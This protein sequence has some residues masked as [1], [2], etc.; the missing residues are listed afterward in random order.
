MCLPGIARQFG[1]DP[2]PAFATAEVDEAMFANPENRVSIAKLG[3]FA[4]EIAR[5]IDR[6]DLGLLIARTYGS[7]SLGPVLPQA[8]QGH[9][10]RAALLNIIRL[11]KH[12]NELALLSLSETDGDAILNYE[13]REPEFEGADIVLV[14]SPR[15]CASRH[16]PVVRQHVVPR[17]SPLLDGATEE[18]LAV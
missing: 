10:V 9:D 16:A 6:P 11:L 17:R 5:L 8:L 3:R 15:Q 2:A 12:H 7:H 14:T 13:L 18:C 1:K 4:S